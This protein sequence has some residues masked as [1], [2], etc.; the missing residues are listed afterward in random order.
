LWRD[1]FRNLVNGDED[2]GGMC[3]AIEWLTEMDDA[4]ILAQGQDWA[5]SLGFHSEA[6]A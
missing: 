6:A 4:Q 5:A 1:Y 3:D 2:S